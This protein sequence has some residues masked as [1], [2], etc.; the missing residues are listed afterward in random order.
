MANNGNSLAHRTFDK[1]RRL[2]IIGFSPIALSVIL[3]QILIRKHLIKL[4]YAIDI[5]T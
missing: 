2:Y 3:S 4:W 5:R 1:L